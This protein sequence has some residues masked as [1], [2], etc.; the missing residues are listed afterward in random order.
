LNERVRVVN[1]ESGKLFYGKVIGEGIVE[2]EIE[3]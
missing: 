1:P 3:N 2:V